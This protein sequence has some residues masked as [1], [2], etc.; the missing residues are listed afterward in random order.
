MQTSD[1]KLRSEAL[2][3]FKKTIEDNIQCFLPAVVS[4]GTVIDEN[5]EY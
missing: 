4:T 2:K 1:P 5:N 3:E